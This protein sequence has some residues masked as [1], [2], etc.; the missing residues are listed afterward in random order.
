MSKKINIEFALGLIILIISI[1]CFFYISTKINL[2]NNIEKFQINSSF[3]DIGNVT[4]GNEVKIKGVKVGEVSSIS[5]DQ[6]NYMAII[7]TSLDKSIKI[8]DDSVFKISN[9]GFIGSP[10]IE[11]QLGNSEKILKNNDNSINNI[12]AISLEEIINNFIFK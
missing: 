4:I 12:D 10:Y 9:N 8:P 5:L 11:I 3:F 2:F 1:I 7:T 6:E